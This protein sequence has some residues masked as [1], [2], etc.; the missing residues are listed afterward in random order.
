[1]ATT[2]SN[3]TINDLDFDSIKANLKSYLSGQT[4]FGDYNFEGAGMNI[5]LDVLAYNTHYEAF[6]NNMIANEMFLDSA[7]NR[8]NVVSIAKPVSYTHLTLP[9]IYSV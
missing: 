9:T 8:D 3:L 5:L 1:M 7:V 2:N 6:Y 4:A